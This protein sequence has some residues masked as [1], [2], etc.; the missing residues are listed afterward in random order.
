VTQ[1]DITAAHELG[2]EIKL[3]AI[4][5]TDNGQVSAR[6]HPAMLPKT[7]PLAAVRDVFNAV[8]VQGEEAGELMFFG[9]GAGG[10][11]TG[12]AVVGD[13]V[14]IA[15][16]ITNGALGQVASYYRNDARIRPILDVPVRYYVV[17]SVLDQPGALASVAGVFA[18]HSVSISSVRQEGSGDE[19]SLLLITHLATE[20]A[21]LETF[22][23]LEAL[24]VVKNIESRMRVEG[25]SEG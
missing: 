10:S 4:G 9:R 18:D 2:Y 25:T 12:A 11:P 24:E 22:G 14:E 20:G 1:A 21:H 17:L 15:R 23:D 7:H 8:F 5:E 6:V 19:A 13:V 16:N 3:L